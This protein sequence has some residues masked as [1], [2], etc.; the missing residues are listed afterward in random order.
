MSPSNYEIIPYRE[1]YDEELLKFESSIVQGTNIQ[2]QMV[3]TH[4]LSRA[5]LFEEHY[6]GM[7]IDVHGDILGTAIAARTTIQINGTTMPVGF[8]LDAKVATSARNRGVGKHM[9]KEMYRRFFSLHGLT[10]NFI[11]A[12]LSNAPVIRMT[13]GILSRICLYDFVYLTIPTKARINGI[14]HMKAGKE[15]FGVR[16]FDAEKIP[17]RYY[18]AYRSGLGCFHMHHVYTLKIRK[19]QGIIKWGMGI[20]K[21]LYPSKYKDVP[22]EG[23]ILSFSILYNQSASNI[24]HLNLVLEDLEQSGIT[25]LLVC[26]RKGD[27]VYRSIRHLAINRYRYYLVTDFPLRSSDAVQLDVRCL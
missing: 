23:G 2:L 22:N 11:T 18:T 4:F 12:K 15:L 7:A 25:H 19:I 3:K 27:M 21:R 5:L 1:D 14:P 16:L 8:G 17:D 13:A 26:C 10:K 20:L 9:A 6:A 24:A